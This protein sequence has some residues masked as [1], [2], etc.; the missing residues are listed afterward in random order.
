MIGRAT[1]LALGVAMCA[2]PLAAQDHTDH[3]AH[4][5]NDRSSHEAPPEQDE[6][7]DHSQHRMRPVAMPEPAPAEPAIDH[8]AHT[9]EPAPAAPP[10]PAAFEG[11]AHA[12]DAIFGERAMAEARARNHATHGAMTTGMVL[13]ERLEA[14]IS[15]GHDAYLWDLQ[16]WYGGDIDRLV[17]KSEGEGAFGGPVEDAELQALWSH[18]IGP[19]FDLQTGLRLDVEPELRSHLV[20]GVQGLAPYMWHLDGAVFVSDRGDLT[21]RIEGE[22]DWK[23][24]Q[25]LILQPRAELELSAQDIAER[26]IGAGPTKIEAGLRLR[27]EL[28]REFA[29]YVGVGYEARL[30]E[31]ADLARAVGDDPDGFAL[32]IGLR[33]WF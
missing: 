17:V 8:S 31:T 22:H 21:A 18:A 12:A 26:G 25:R 30:G 3:S 4:R 10:P 9:M 24:T 20:L 33:A 5:A 15:D 32:L 14:R 19:W 7:T 13:I 11:P 1:S 2:Q 28:A 27:Y 23:L 6:A 29:P 16:G